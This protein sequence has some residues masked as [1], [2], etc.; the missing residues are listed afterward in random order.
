MKGN[1]AAVRAQKFILAAIVTAAASLIVG[2]GGGGGTQTVPAKPAAAA[3]NVPAPAA[4]AT[5]KA[6]SSAVFT[7]TLPNAASATATHRSPA[8]VSTGTQSIAISATIGSATPVPVVANL[9]ATSP[10]CATTT[11]G[12]TCSVAVPAPVGTDTFSVTLYSGQNATGSVL[13]SGSISAAVTAL[14]ANTVP[15]TLSGTVATATIVVQNG[16]A[17]VPGTAPTSLPVIVTAKD[18]SG[19]TIIGTYTNALTLTDSDTTTVTALSATSVPSSSTAIA[20]AFTPGNG[21]LPNGGPVTI[22]ATGTGLGSVTPGTFQYVPVVQSVA[23]TVSPAILQGP[24]TGTASLSIVAKDSTNTAITVPGSY[25]TPIAVTDNDAT[26]GISLSAASFTAPGQTITV[27]YS[28]LATTTTTAFTTSTVGTVA[29]ASL[30]IA[31]PHQSLFVAETSSVLVFAPGANGNVAPIRQIAG[32][33]TGISS[34][35]AVVLD[36]AGN[37]YVSNHGNNSIT[38]YSPDASGNA[39][40]IR[41]IAGA[42]T[43]MTGLFQP[44]GMAL[45]ASG[46]LFVTLYNTST[47]LGGTIVT[48]APG[49]N[50]NA[51]PLSII[52]GTD[53]SN[54]NGVLVDAAGDIDAAATN[55]DG[56]FTYAPGS[57]GNAAPASSIT[58]ATTAITGVVMQEAYD[59]GG[60]RWLALDQS[61]LSRVVE[62]SAGATGN[63]APANQIIGVAGTYLTNVRGIAFDAQGNLYV[64]NPPSTA[65]LTDYIFVY[66]PG[67]TERQRRSEP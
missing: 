39:T 41:T 36:G 2:C 57:S 11:A 7:L 5:A 49:A 24:A 47:Y 46:D 40:P 10:A 3:S 20:L 28:G 22:G 19:A 23:F 52:S 8:Y 18:A 61:P 44:F 27:T 32:A 67:A 50:G 4:T 21:A 51:T 17:V 6:M 29:P 65:P 13:A 64:A 26:G 16:N 66:A 63:I 14:V 56:I 12:L 38:V 33:N 58:G 59:L 53:I 55:P 34:P 31:P 15:I 1:G 48:F 62:F 43:G 54:A 42:N 35:R 37:I 30:A 9:S 25:I 45:D 60:N